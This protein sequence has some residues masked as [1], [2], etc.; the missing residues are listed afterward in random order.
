MSTG[1][2]AGHAFMRAGNHAAARRVAENDMPLAR[3]ITNGSVWVYLL[4]ILT[5]GGPLAALLDRRKEEV[6]FRG[7]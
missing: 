2:N 1:L 4:L 6:N 7:Y 3:E 5:I